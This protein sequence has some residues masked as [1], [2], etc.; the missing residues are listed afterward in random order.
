MV[1]GIGSGILFAPPLI[2]VQSQV[3]QEDVAT[4]TST[5]SFIRNIALTVSVVIGGTIFMNSMDARSS[6]LQD[7]GLPSPLLHELSGENAMANVMLG[8]TLQNPNWELAVKEAFSW[9]TRNMWITYTI[10]AFLGVVASLFVEASHL[11]TE[12]TETV[13]GLKKERKDIIPESV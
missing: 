10:F 6:F 1:G 9:A 12:H 5:L 7:A 11:G 13:T 8:G 3:K 2:A 4:A